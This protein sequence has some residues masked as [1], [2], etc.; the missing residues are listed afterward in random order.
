MQCN[1]VEYDKNH[2][3]VHVTNII[4]SVWRLTGFYGFPERSR[5]KDSWEMIKMLSRRSSLPCCLLGDCN[6]MLCEEDKKG[7]HKHPRYLL[8]GFKNTIEECGLIEL[9]L[10]GVNSL[11]RRAGAQK[12]GLG[13]E[14]IE[15]LLQRPGGRC[16]R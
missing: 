1:V 10:M 13:K 9:D 4:N 2:I 6:D 8:D 12:I 5:R 7:A 15:L 16:F 14:L 3:D 11:G